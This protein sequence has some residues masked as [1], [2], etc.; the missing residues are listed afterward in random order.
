MLEEEKQGID[1]TLESQLIIG[2]M[3]LLTNQV[4]SKYVLL[5]IDIGQMDVLYWSPKKFEIIVNK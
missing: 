5:N 3:N 2:S 1:K 4:E